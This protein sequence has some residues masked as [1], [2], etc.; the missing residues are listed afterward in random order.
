MQFVEGARGEASLIDEGL[1]GSFASGSIT[2]VNPR[3]KSVVFR[4]D[5]VCT[6]YCSNSSRAAYDAMPSKPPGL[7]LPLSLPALI[8]TQ[9]DNDEIAGQKLAEDVEKSRYSSDC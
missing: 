4:Y 6:T 9:L 5:E 2:T 8:C 7:A 3:S 1:E